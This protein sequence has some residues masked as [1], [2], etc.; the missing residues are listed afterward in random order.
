MCKGGG[1]AC[2]P[3]YGMG[4]AGALF[5]FLSH[6]PTFW[7]GVVGILK[8]LLWPAFLVFKLFSM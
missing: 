4:V 8:A 5:Y 1:N 3:I 2:G 7:I 6:A